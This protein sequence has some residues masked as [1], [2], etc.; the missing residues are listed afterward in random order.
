MRMRS[1]AATSTSRLRRCAIASPTTLA[2]FT[3][4][5]RQRRAPGTAYHA[6]VAAAERLNHEHR[7]VVAR[8][9]CLEARLCARFF[10]NLGV[11]LWTDPRPPRTTL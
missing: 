8:R 7:Y 6:L 9:I 5:V 4:R 1:I 10:F 3:R 11:V 2:S